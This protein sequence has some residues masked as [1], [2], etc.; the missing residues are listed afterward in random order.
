MRKEG[1]FDEALDLYEELLRNFPD[2]PQAE[3][4]FATKEVEELKG[5]IGFV[6]VRG[7]EPGATVVIDGRSRGTYP[8]P[9][10][11]RVSVGS[12]VVRAFKE[13]FLPF[14]SRVEVAGAQTLILE[15]HLGALVQSGRLRVTEQSGRAVDVVVDGVVL[16]KTPWEGTLAVGDHTLVLRGDGNLGTQ[17]AAATV[18][19]NQ[20]TSLTLIA[21][22]LDAIARVEPTPV[23][24][25]VTIDGVAV[26]RGVWEGKMRAGGHVVEATLDGFLVFHKE[27]ALEKGRREVVVATLARDPNS[28]LWASREPAHFVLEVGG[29]F[30]MTPLFGGD[31]VGGCTASC[32]RTLPIGGTGV[33]RA[34]Y[35]FPQGFFGL[36]L[37]GGYLAFSESLSNRA[38]T[39][40][41]V[42]STTDYGTVDDKIDLAGL[43]AGL[44]AY[45]RLGDVWPLTFR[46]G[47]GVFLAPRASDDRSGSFTTS[48]QGRP[49]NA[50]YSVAASESHTAVFLYAAPEV[51]FGRRIG[52]HL[53][54]SVGA[55]LRVLAAAAQP[56]WQDSHP[57][58][59]GP[60]NTQGDGQGGFNP[61]NRPPQTMTGSFLLA[62]EPGLGFRYAF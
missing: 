30:V 56:S 55:T 33:L 54:V 21:E 22:D 14:E 4:D 8:L 43:L 5:S 48:S 11:L 61:P 45:Y 57:L 53:E 27:L 39:L 37:E 10:P 42:R 44:T 50:A 15:A 1:R 9:G 20:L 38:A 29:A 2:L 16:G 59:E 41:S 19:L 34:E 28:P 58:P 31:L 18:R 25:T 40:S 13:G 12:H 3:K 7:A 6:D 52:N 62:I 23:S 26:G 32:S 49:P 17:P 60:P 24:A 46:F 35:Q 47:L 36:G 51:R